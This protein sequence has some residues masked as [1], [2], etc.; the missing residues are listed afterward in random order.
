[1]RKFLVALAL[2]AGHFIA[3]TAQA[4]SLYV[5]LTSVPGD[6]TVL[7]LVAVNPDADI[8]RVFSGAILPRGANGVGNPGTPTEQIGVAPGTTRVV[9]GPSGVG[10]WRLKGYSGLQ[11]SARMRVPGG[12]S[13]QQGDAVPIF[14][15]DNAIA[16]NTTV[17]TTSLLAANGFRNDVGLFNAGEVSANCIAKVLL[18]D[19]TQ[20]GPVFGLIV[21]PLSFSLYEHIPQ[22]F[23]G[24]AQVSNARLSMRC[25]QKFSVLSR[26]VNPQ[27]GYVSFHTP[28]TAIGHGFPDPGTQPTPTPSPT[29]PGN[30]PPPATATETYSQPGNFYTAS[31]AEPQRQ[32]TPPFTPNVAFKTL[33]VN[34]KLEHGGWNEI[35][36][37]AVLNLLWLT[38]GDFYGD[39]FASITARGPSRNVVRI[40]TTIDMPQGAATSRSKTTILEPGKVYTFDY[41][42]DHPN[43]T[44]TLTVSDNLGPVK[45]ITG[46]T[47]GPVWTRHKPWTLLLSEAPREGHAPNYSWK[48]SDLV[49][50]LTP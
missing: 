48:Y 18:A 12:A 3:V 8:T 46:P 42:Y 2:C 13:Q 25:D 5:P 31:L 32:L 14:S 30:S 17:E 47:T 36:P 28:A 35:N 1:M 21:A 26:T 45:I 33:R 38:R 41:L 7:E 10:L 16:A 11:L 34:F 15:L 4:Q 24:G 6:G 27:T 19:G 23:L 9:V 44:F 20:V 22:A 49:I 29:P 40:E 50:T 43:G 37:E 39:T